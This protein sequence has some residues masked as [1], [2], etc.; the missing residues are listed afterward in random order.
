VVGVEFYRFKGIA[1]VLHLRTLTVNVMQQAIRLS[2]SLLAQLGSG[3]DCWQNSAPEGHSNLLIGPLP[4]KQPTGPHTHQPIG[5]CPNPL[6]QFLMY[7][8]S[9]FLEI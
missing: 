8:R 3:A 9:E 4:I 2:G 7:F 6:V 1:A 5:E